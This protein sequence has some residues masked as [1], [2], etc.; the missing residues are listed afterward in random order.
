MSV[1]GLR[2]HRDVRSVESRRVSFPVLDEDVAM[3]EK[4]PASFLQYLAKGW[5]HCRRDL[6]RIILLPYCGSTVR[7]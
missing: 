7:V 2:R 1:R 5:L 6:G 3:I 4:I